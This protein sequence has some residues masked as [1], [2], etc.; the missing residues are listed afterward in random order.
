MKKLKTWIHLYGEDT[1]KIAKNL[2]L[3]ATIF[4][5][6]IYAP[7]LLRQYLI[8]RF[9]SEAI[10]I[11]EQI[12]EKKGIQEAREGGKVVTVAYKIDYHFNSKYSVIQRSEILYKNSLV[13]SQWYQLA[14]LKIGD[15]INVRYDS[16][17]NKSAIEL[18]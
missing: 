8:D 14:Q 13:R 12:D 17:S 5:F 9:D 1:W 4:A 18:Q 16:A 3:A 15:T 7:R 2:T 6:C 10:G 11:I